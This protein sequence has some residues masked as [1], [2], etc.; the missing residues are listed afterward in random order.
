M[1]VQWSQKTSVELLG[2]NWGTQAAALE[3][4][5][6]LSV[7]GEGR[8]REGPYLLCIAAL[9]ELAAAWLSQWSVASRA[10]SGCLVEPAVLS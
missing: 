5:P 10:R 3:S 8:V 1:P 4:S 6:R 9:W 7:G 2:N